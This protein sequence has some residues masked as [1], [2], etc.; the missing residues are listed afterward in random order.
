MKHSP[1][2]F[3]DIKNL[4]HFLFLSATPRPRADAPVCPEK[5]KNRKHLDPHMGSI[6][7]QASRFK[8]R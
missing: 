5:K 4:S 1:Q 6:D 8:A 2:K 3:K 7:G